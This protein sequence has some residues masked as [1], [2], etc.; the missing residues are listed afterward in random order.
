MDGKI[1]IS[2]L[3]LCSPQAKEDIELGKPSILDQG[4]KHEPNKNALHTSPWQLCLTWE[5]AWKL[6]NNSN[7]IRRSSFFIGM[8]CNKYKGPPTHLEI[9]NRLLNIPPTMDHQ[10]C[11]TIIHRM[12]QKPEASHL[13]NNPATK[14]LQS[15]QSNN[16]PNRSG[17]R[18]SS[19][20]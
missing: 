18:F 13:Q 9:P 19:P 11:L 3:A 1:K 7:S 4:A 14:C 8:A 16:N 17:K 10:Y 2:N 6:T 12:I 5:G 20:I 15:N